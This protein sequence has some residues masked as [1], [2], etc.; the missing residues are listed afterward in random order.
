M[1]SI[2]HS[3]RAVI[4]WVGDADER[5]SDILHVVSRLSSELPSTYRSVNSHT[6]DDDHF[7]RYLAS[8]A[9]IDLTAIKLS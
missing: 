5:V 3:A 6:I 1:E 2:D 8:V 4:I 7:G 9:E